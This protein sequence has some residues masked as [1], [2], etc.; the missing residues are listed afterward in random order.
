MSNIDD[1]K[2]KVG[3]LRDQLRQAEASLN[4]AI[5]AASPYEIGQIW[6]RTDQSGRMVRGQIVRFGVRFHP[7]MP[8]LRL[9]KA[10][11][12]LGKLEADMY[13]DDWKKT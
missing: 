6:T 12:T 10:D 4:A 2:T 1:L 7:T 9:F 11:G 13:Q 5:I 3:Q 8:V